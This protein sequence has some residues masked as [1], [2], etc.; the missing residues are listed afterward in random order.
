LAACNEPDEIAHVA[1]RYEVGRRYLDAKHPFGGQDDAD[2][3]E[4]IPARDVACRRRHVDTDGIVIENV[5][6]DV[7]KALEDLKL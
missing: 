2:I 5:S 6:D 4:A 7:P 1:Q 3:R